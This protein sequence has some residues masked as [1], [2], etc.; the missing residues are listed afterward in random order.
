MLD[1]SI[2][3]ERRAQL[4][5]IRAQLRTEFFGLDDIIDRVIESVSAWYIF[6]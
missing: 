2:I 6:P 3:A 5:T 1:K 4:D